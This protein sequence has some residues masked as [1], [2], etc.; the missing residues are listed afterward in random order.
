[1][2]SRISVAAASHG[3]RRPTRLRKRVGLA[4]L[5]MAVDLVGLACSG[6]A[7][8][9]PSIPPLPEGERGASSEAAS[10]LRGVSY[11]AASRLT[12]H[13]APKGARA[14][15]QGESRESVAAVCSLPRRAF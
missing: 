8:G 5:T 9:T 4:R 11:D 7:H 14:L 1:M 2:P 15:P 13:R 10:R 3:T 12:P 6:N